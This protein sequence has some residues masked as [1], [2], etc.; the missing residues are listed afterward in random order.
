MSIFPEFIQAFQKQLESTT[1]G[2]DVE[3]FNFQIVKIQQLNNFTFF[4]K[5]DFSKSKP[6]RVAY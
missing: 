3:R 5:N 2:N 4:E 1:H 6:Q